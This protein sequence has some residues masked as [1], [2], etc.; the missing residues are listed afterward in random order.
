MGFF[1]E[2]AFQ[3]RLGQ[4]MRLPTT[5]LTEPVAYPP[6]LFLVG[7]MDTKRFDAWDQDLLSMTTIIQWR[8]AAVE[9]Y[10]PPSDVNAMPGGESEFLRSLIRGERATRLKLQRVLGARLPTV[11]PLIQIDSLLGRHVPDRPLSGLRDSLIYLSN[12]W[13]RRGA[14]LFGPSPTANLEIALDLNIAQSVLPCAEAAIQHSPALRDELR[15]ML[16]G[17]FPRSAALLETLG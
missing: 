2:L 16:N 3:L 5:H 1:S 7:T 9:T 14:G 4:I 13:T 8:A 12:A 6:N 10:R 17:K 11:W 15:A